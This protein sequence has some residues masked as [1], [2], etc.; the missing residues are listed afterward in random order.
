MKT[1]I[2]A[3]LA[4]LFLSGCA[5]TVVKRGESFELKKKSVVVLRQGHELQARRVAV[6]ADS[7]AVTGRYSGVETRIP[8]HA[9]GKVVEL[10]AFGGMLRGAVDGT[11]IGVGAG[12]VMVPI[13]AS[14]CEGLGCITIPMI[15]GVTGIWGAGGGA[16]VGLL[17][18]R[19]ASYSFEGAREPERTPSPTAD[20]SDT[21]EAWDEGLDLWHPDSAR[22]AN[23]RKGFYGGADIGF[24]HAGQRGAGPAGSLYFGGSLPSGRMLGGRLA[25]QQHEWN[26]AGWYH[27]QQLDMGLQLETRALFPWPKSYWR[28]GAG[29]AY[30]AYEDHDDL[31][32]MDPSL[33]SSSRSSPGVSSSA[34]V[35]I[36]IRMTGRLDLTMEAGLEGAWYFDGQRHWA[37]TTTLGFVLF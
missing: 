13:A 15:P 27:N 8:L 30:Y 7:L 9:V 34:G 22:I 19:G 4:A 26:S 29:G 21:A 32:W 11:A 14:S 23:A 35:G 28:A 33:P 20:L 24:V 12:L 18:G 25:F 6:E 36:L 37:V 31:Y 1:L 2:G 5:A 10:D 17:R 16:F 3:A